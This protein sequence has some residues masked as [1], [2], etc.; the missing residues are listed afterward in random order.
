MRCKIC[1]QPSEHIF[2]GRIL[3]KY[4]VGYW[5]CRS[6]G[7]MQTDEP[8][9]LDEAYSSAISDLDLGPVN[10]ALTGS[11]FVESVILTGFNPNAKFLDWGGGYGVFT[12]LMRD[13]GYDFYW[14]DCYCNNLFAKQ[15]QFDKD[16]SYE[17]ITA[18]E[19]FEHL[20]NPIGEIADMLKYSSNLLFTTLIP[21]RPV[22]GPNDWWYLSLE[23][24]QHVSIYSIQSLNVIA[25]RF[26]LHLS[27]DGTGTHLLSH[28]P[29]SN[30]LFKT[31]TRRRRAAA[32]V[33]R[34]IA[35]HKLRARSLLTEDVR[36]VTGWK[37]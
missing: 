12:R 6:C 18:F 31:V 1:D 10:R 28:R 34:L 16:A 7:F 29:Y 3:K 8:Y 36:A 21:S 35:R 11:A 2:N 15:F 23:H 5:N 20:V 24:G 17:L 19:V 32:T 22:T 26:G 4:D 30:V 14:H 37:L 9:W 27:T 25:E 33:L 13:Y